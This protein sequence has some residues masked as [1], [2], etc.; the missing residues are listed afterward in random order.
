MN[1]IAIDLKNIPSLAQLQHEKKVAIYNGGEEASTRAIEL[2][3]EKLIFK[4][5]SRVALSGTAYQN[6]VMK[7]SCILGHHK[8]NKSGVDTIVS[9]VSCFTFCGMFEA[10]TS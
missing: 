6:G 1:T 4:G 2:T 9:S 10:I 5:K 7:K 3:I 8:T